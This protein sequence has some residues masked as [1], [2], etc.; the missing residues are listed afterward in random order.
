MPN[1]PKLGL[2][3]TR[4]ERVIS[5]VG[6]LQQ[7]RRGR[8]IA[9]RRIY[10]TTDEIAEVKRDI[11]WEVKDETSANDELRQALLAYYTSDD[12]R[13][14]L[15]EAPQWLRDKPIEEIVDLL[16]QSFPVKG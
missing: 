6:L 8:K 12:G 1:P 4:D 3:R 14:E 10:I 7:R 11:M 5:A 16:M 9:S 2:P 13:E 15:E